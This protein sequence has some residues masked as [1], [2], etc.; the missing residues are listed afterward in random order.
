MKV[1]F[2]HLHSPHFLQIQCITLAIGSHNTSSG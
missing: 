2:Y 1:A